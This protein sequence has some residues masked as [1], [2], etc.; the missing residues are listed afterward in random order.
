MDLFFLVYALASENGQRIPDLPISL[1]KIPKNLFE[2]VIFFVRKKYVF[3]SKIIQKTK[4]FSTGKL[5][6]LIKKRFFG[7]KFV[8]FLDG[9]R[10]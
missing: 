4:L 3:C 7:T 8:K 6:D 10:P 2:K 5:K 1:Q 9:A